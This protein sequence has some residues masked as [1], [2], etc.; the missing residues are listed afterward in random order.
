MKYVFI[1]FCAA[2]N[3]PLLNAH[4]GMST[5]ELYSHAIIMGVRE[6]ALRLHCLSTKKRSIC[7]ADIN[8]EVPPLYDHDTEDV[9][10]KNSQCV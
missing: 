1:F 10:K 7:T 5:I 2:A 8:I 9:L 3:Y 6:E 4:M